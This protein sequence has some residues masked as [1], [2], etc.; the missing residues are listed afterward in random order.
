MIVDIE[1][2]GQPVAMLTDEEAPHA[3]HMVNFLRLMGL[4]G[5]WPVVLDGH[6]KVMLAGVMCPEIERAARL[7]LECAMFDAKPCY[8]R[9]Y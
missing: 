2:N 8:Q 9:D 4:F 3:E 1:I 7:A 5:C 6:T